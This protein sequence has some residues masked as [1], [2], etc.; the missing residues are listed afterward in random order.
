MSLLKITYEK[1]TTRRE[2]GKT[3]LQSLVSVNLY[4]FPSFSRLLLNPWIQRVLM[5]LCLQNHCYTIKCPTPT[6]FLTFLF[7]I[8]LGSLIRQGM[9]IKVVVLNRKK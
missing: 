1:L 9:Q 6:S 8:L 5:S 4:F 3:V 2:K 7:P